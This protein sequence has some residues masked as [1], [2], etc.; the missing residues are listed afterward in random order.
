MQR[1]YV[2]C[3]RAQPWAKIASLYTHQHTQLLVEG[4][5]GNYMTL[6]R[7]PSVPEIDLQKAD[8]WEPAVE[9]IPSARL[10]ANL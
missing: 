1:G 2:A 10:Q 6:T 7:C 9:R 3:L 4:F 5:P 8:F